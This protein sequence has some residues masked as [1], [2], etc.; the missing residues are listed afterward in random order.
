M[1]SFMSISAR[2]QELFRKNRGGGGGKRP[3]P[4]AVTGYVAT[5]F[6][7]YLAMEKSY[8]YGNGLRLSFFLVE[9]MFSRQGAGIRSH[10][11]YW[12]TPSRVVGVR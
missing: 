7:T 5:I 8:K 10:V 6:A 4:Q 3:P 1:P 11:L 9:C 12:L 2:V